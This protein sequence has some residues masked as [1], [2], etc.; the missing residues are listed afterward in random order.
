MSF[1]ATLTQRAHVYARAAGQESWQ[2][3]TTEPVP[4]RIV[5]L[6]RREREMAWARLQT[7]VTHRGRC[8]PRPEIRPGRKLVINEAAGSAGQSFIIVAVRHIDHPAPAGHLAVD[9]SEIDDQAG[10]S[11]A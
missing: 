3:L 7:E 5:A 8:L 9:L 2:K 11:P 1:Y 10:S 4:C 6:P